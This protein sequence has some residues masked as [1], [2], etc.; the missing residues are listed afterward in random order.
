MITPREKG[1]VG[2]VARQREKRKA[3]IVLLGNPER[4][5]LVGRHRPTQKFKSVRELE[6]KWIHLA[7]DR[8]QLRALLNTVV[9]FWI[10]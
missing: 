1:R 9:N 5:R 3:W 2:Y 6:S 4:K 8:D 7:Q 10:I